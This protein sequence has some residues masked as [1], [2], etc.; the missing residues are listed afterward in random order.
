M[1]GNTFIQ[2]PLNLNEEETLKRFLNKLIQEL[3]VAFGNRGDTPIFT[4]NP[5]QD[6][7]QQLVLDNPTDNEKK[8]QEKLNEIIGVLQKSNITS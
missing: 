7:I 4:N 3:D 2:I 8:I 6:S 5:K 1:V